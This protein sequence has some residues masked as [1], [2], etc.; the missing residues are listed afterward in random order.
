MRV[1]KTRLV[2]QW[3]GDTLFET[4]SPTFI[5]KSYAVDR[6]A[7]IGYVVAYLNLH[8]NGDSRYQAYFKGQKHPKGLDSQLEIFQQHM[9][10][11][12]LVVANF[13]KKSNRYL[14]NNNNAK[15]G[16]IYKQLKDNTGIINYEVGDSW[17]MDKY[18]P[19]K[20]QVMNASWD[21]QGSGG[22]SRLRFVY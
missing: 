16:R 12:K 9:T 18:S 21:R 17:K 10:P 1:L 11:E 20:T 4:Y 6:R 19:H 5:Y 15:V 22:T 7:V 14:Y 8:V 13:K 2:L 3:P